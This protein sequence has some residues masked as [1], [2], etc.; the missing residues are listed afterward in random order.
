[1]C[2]YCS[3]FLDNP[4]AIMTE[5]GTAEYD[6]L[7]QEAGGPEGKLADGFDQENYAAHIAATRK[8]KDYPNWL[9]PVQDRVTLF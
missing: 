8:P 4:P 1:M 2:S 5:Q 3:N 9:D 7:V 6:Q